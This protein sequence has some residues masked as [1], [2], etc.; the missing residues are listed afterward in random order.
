MRNQKKEINS[1]VADRPAGGLSPLTVLGEALVWSVLRRRA[2]EPQDQLW[3][4][5]TCR[6]PPPVHQGCYCT[7]LQTCRISDAEGKYFR[8]TKNPST[9]RFTG[10]TPHSWTLGGCLMQKEQQWANTA[11]GTAVLS[12][13]SFESCYILPPLLTKSSSELNRFLEPWQQIWWQTGSRKTNCR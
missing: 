2:E 11:P 12:L 8:C 7:K 4:W 9:V 10:W 13:V 5:N 3:R 6:L 1:V